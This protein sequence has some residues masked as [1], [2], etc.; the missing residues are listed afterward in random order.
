MEG[1]LPTQ[2][3]QHFLSL[4]P[5]V[6]D[7]TVTLSMTFDPQDSQELARRLNFIVLD[8]Q[9]FKS[10]LE[11]ESAFSLAKA[12]G[13]RDVVGAPPTNAWPPSR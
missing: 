4:E 7:G 8:E 1:E 10:Y 9:G 2:F 3:D 6:R 11:G 5:D 13:S 12:A